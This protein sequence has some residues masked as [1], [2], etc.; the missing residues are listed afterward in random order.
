VLLPPSGVPAIVSVSDLSARL[1]AS[2]VA[3]QAHLISD[4]SV[5]VCALESP[6]D[7]VQEAFRIGRAGGA[8]TVLNASPAA[9]LAPELVVQTDV[10]VVNEEE[11]RLLTGAPSA[12][13]VAAKLAQALDPRAVIVTAGALGAFLAERGASVARI[14]A[15]AVEVVDTTG[16]GD[17]FVGA[18]A[19]RMREGVRLA[20]AVPFAVKAASLSCTRPFTM[21]SFPTRAELGTDRGP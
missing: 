5:L 10:L 15:P 19:A 4:A 12:E 16:A 3:S 20:E 11:G 1:D 13:V 14:P 17:A 21:P 18:M 2:A 8:V 9:P 7:G 6:V